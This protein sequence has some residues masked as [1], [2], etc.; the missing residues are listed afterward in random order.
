MTATIEYIDSNEMLSEVTIH[1]QVVYLAG[2]VPD[3]DAADLETQTREVFANIDK[4]LAKA[5]SDKSRLLSAQLFVA[6]LADFAVIN[7][8]WESWLKG[9]PKPVRAT[10]QAQLV[11]PKWRLEIMVIAAQN[12]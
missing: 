8:L 5:G 1:N 12:V 6:D 11:N 9:Y 10:V 2:Q 4:M 7:A 3:N